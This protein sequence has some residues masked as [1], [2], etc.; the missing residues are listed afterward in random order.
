MKL[1]TLVEYTLTI[2]RNNKKTKITVDQGQK[3]K[4]FNKEDH[5]ECRKLP[6][7]MKVGD[8]FQGMPILKIEL[9]VLNYY[10]KGKKVNKIP[11]LNNLDSFVEYMNNKY[12]DG[13]WDPEKEK[14]VLQKYSVVCI[15]FLYMGL[16][17]ENLFGCSVYVPGK[18]LKDGF[19][20]EYIPDPKVMPELDFIN[21]E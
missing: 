13:E 11:I 2:L 14:G 7:E 10:E 17:V 18:I 15:R 6:S 9:P 21:V 3:Y 8:L 20:Y 12:P 5:K 4:I 1:R 16:L 19:L